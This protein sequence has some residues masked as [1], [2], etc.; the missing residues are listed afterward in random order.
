MSAPVADSVNRTFFMGFNEPNNLHNCNTP[1][2]KVTA[3]KLCPLF[4]AFQHCKS[5][6]KMRGNVLK[7]TALKLFSMFLVLLVRF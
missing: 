2:A 6:K 7:V 5:A 4:L 1:A 3:L